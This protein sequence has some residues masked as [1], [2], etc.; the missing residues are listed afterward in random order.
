MAVTKTTQTLSATWTVSQFADAVKQ[1]FIDAGWMT[2]WY[3][4]FELSTN[5]LCRVLRVVYDATTSYGTTYYVFCFDTNRISVQTV[6]GFNTTTNLPIGTQYL[7]YVDSPFTFPGASYYGPE[8][9]DLTGFNTGSTTYIDT[10]R[11]GI[12]PRISFVSF[13]NRDIGYRLCLLT[14]ITPEFALQSWIDTNI[15]S[16]NGLHSF[17][18]G[19]EGNVANLRITESDLIRRDLFTG[20]AFRGVTDRRQFCQYYRHHYYYRSIAA[21]NNSITSN[22]RNQESY[23]HVPTFSNLNFTSLSGPQSPFMTNWP[24]SQLSSEVVPSD[25]ALWAP[26]GGVNY[27]ATDTLLNQND[28]SQW[29]IIR[30]TTTDSLEKASLYLIGRTN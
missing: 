6:T 21:V 29:E 14:L 13:R 20:Q 23:I 15:G 18:F 3:H 9:L 8:V 22:F 30:G 24:I 5:R 19:V 17:M 12:D 10:Y 27:Q 16:I 25:F 28:D 1:C 26:S 7:D 11:S 2:D 4:A